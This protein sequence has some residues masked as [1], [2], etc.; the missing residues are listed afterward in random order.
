MPPRLT[1]TSL[2]Q[3]P[4]GVGAPP[5]HPALLFLMLHKND[6]ASGQIKS[7]CVMILLSPFSVARKLNAKGKTNDSRNE[8]TKI[9][10]EKQATIHGISFQRP[11][12]AAINTQE[13]HI[14]KQIKAA[15]KK[16]LKLMILA[17]Y[18]P[19]ER[20]FAYS[21]TDDARPISRV[22]CIKCQRSIGCLHPLSQFVCQCRLNV[23]YPSALLHRP[24][25]TCMFHRRMSATL[26][27]A[28]GPSVLMSFCQLCS[29]E[30][31]QYSLLRCVGVWSTRQLLLPYVNRH[32]VFQT[33]D[34]RYAVW[35]DVKSNTPRSSIVLSGRNARNVHSIIVFLEEKSCCTYTSCCFIL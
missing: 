15:M 20:C 32:V 5:S 8:S 13:I 23:M 16:V 1:S 11:M 12:K 21:V 14:Y 31:L 27:D 2:Q 30:R 25:G 17:Y 22:T 24:L 35:F 19:R 34:Q 4:L 9:S 3:S 7:L 33:A 18:Q 26:D 10:T 6:R 29:S 28:V